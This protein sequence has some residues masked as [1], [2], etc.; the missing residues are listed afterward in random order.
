[1]EATRFSET[2][3]CNKPTRRHIPDGILH[4]YRR[5]NIKSHKTVKSLQVFIVNSV[6]WPA[7]VSSGDSMLSAAESPLY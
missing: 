1:M 2:S 5:E 6:G 3:V 7:G 4:S